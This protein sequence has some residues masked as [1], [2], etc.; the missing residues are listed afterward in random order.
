MKQYVTPKNP[1]ARNRPERC[2]ARVLV[3]R[4]APLNLPVRPFVSKMLPVSKIFPIF[5]RYPAVPAE[6]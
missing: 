2:T 5:V 1:N 3:R 6:K 4:I